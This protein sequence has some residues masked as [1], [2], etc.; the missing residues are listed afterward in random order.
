MEPN[1][2]LKPNERASVYLPWSGDKKA[3]YQW[4]KEICGTRTRPE[5]NRTTR[6]FD[7]N[8]KYASQVIAALVEKY[9]RVLVTIHGNVSTTCVDKCWTANRETIVNCLCSCAG[10]N[11][12]T[13]SP[14]GIEVKVGLSVM[15]TRG[16]QE[17]IVSANGWESI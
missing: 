5:F 1:L 9:E 7:F 2:I 4:L 11:H 14:I 3:N 6:Y 13:G 12:G 8:R 17:F 16:V 15:N 10:R